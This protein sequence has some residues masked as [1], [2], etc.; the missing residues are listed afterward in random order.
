ME[1]IYYSKVEYTEVLDC[2]T[3]QKRI[4]LLNLPMREL[5]YQVLEGVGQMQKVVFSY[6][7]KLSEE[8]IK[9]LLPYCNALDFEPYRDKEMVMG[10]VGYIGYRDQANMYFRAITDSYLP[11]LELPMDYHYDEAHIWPSEKLYRYLVQTFFEN[12]KRLKQYKPTYG[13]LSLFFKI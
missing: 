7:M 11:K 3:H 4:T 6:G 5:S 12:N 10:D 2:F 13:G 1:P 8:Q 9:D